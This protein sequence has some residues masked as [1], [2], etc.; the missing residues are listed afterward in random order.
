MK[1]IHTFHH[2]QRCKTVVI[3]CSDNYIGSHFISVKSSKL[4]SLA[5]VLVAFKTG[6][7]S[8]INSFIRSLVFLICSFF[9]LNFS[10]LSFTIDMISSTSTRVP[11]ISRW[12]FSHV[13]LFRIIDLSCWTSVSVIL[14]SSSLLSSIFSNPVC[15]C[16]DYILHE[17]KKKT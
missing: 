11:F 3:L 13:S 12:R 4:I 5:K 10:V 1:Y 16:R 2:K 6:N 17:K 9:T 15:I 7:V 14:H 8:S